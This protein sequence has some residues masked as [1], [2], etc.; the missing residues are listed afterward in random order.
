MDLGATICT[1][2]KPRCALCPWREACAAFKAGDAEDYP[3]KTAKPE[4]PILHA[5][6]YWMTLPDGRVV[7]R[8]RKEEGLLGGMMEIPTNTWRAAPW[9]L[10]EARGVA[11]VAAEWRDLPGNIRHVF[12]HI[13]LRLTLLAGRVRKIPDGMLAAPLDKLGDYALP[14]VM[15]KIVNAAAKGG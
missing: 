8:R 13:D 15:R 11:P 3:R 6:A 4:R 10:D 9:T 7:L 2:R 5:V 1:P 12:T 14:S